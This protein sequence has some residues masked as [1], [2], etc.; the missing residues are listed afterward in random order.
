MKINGTL[1]LCGSAL[2]VGIVVGAVWLLRD[3]Y[4]AAIGATLDGDLSQVT[5]QPHV[6]RESIVVT[7]SHQMESIREMVKG[8]RPLSLA[9]YPV[10]SCSLTFH[11][12]DG[13]RVA[14]GVSP[15]GMTRQN[16]FEQIAE[17][18][19]MLSYVTLSWEGHRRAAS[20]APFVAVLREQQRVAAPAHE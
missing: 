8:A 5:F 18:H 20:S 1:L 12:A 16:F 13:R 10:P 17:K 11:F 7:D 9:S 6:D 3:R 19:S 4:P 14:L 15:T 2:V